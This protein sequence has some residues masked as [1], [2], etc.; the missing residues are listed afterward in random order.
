M[1]S[2]RLTALALGITGAWL[3][4]PRHLAPSSEDPSPT[5]TRARAETR[6]PDGV[7]HAEEAPVEARDRA[8]WS[9]RLLVRLAPG[10]DA[11]AVAARAGATV[12]RAPGATGLAT[13]AVPQGATPRAL[14]SRLAQDPEVLSTARSGRVEGVGDSATLGTLASV[15]WHLRSGRVQPPSR[16]LSTITVAVVD[17]GVA[18]PSAAGDCTPAPSLSSLVTV[19]P[20]DFVNDDGQACDDHQHGTHI[21]SLIASRGAVMGF[22]PHV[23]IM[24]I[25]VLDAD[26]VGDEQGLIDGLRWAVAQGA[27]VIN[28]SLSF[29]EGY[30]PSAD[31]L[32]ALREAADAGVVMVGAAGNDGGDNVT[33]PAASPLVIS[34][35]ASTLTG[36][37]AL[38]LSTYSNVGAQLDLQAP[39]GSLDADM[40]GDGYADGV[41][42]ETILPGDPDSFGYYFYEGTSQAAALVS[43]SAAWLLAY[44]AAPEEVSVALQA[45]ARARPTTPFIDGEGAGSLDLKAALALVGAGV[46]GD[47]DRVYASVLPTLRADGA[48]GAIVPTARIL[49]VNEEGAPL[50]GVAVI[51]QAHGRDG[52]DERWTCAA[53]VAGICDVELSAVSDEDGALA[54]A[55]RFTVDGVVA[56]GVMRSPTSVL[57]GSDGLE[58]LSAALGEVDTSASA[59]AFIWEEGEIDGLGALAASVTLLDLGGDGARAPTALVLTAAMAEQLFEAHALELD[60]SGSGLSTDALGV[61]ASGL[62][63]DALGIFTSSGLSTDALGVVSLSDT[64]GSGLSTDALGATEGGSVV[65]VRGSGAAATLLGVSALALTSPDQGEDLGLGLSGTPIFPGT[66]A[67]AEALQ[68]TLTQQS[69]ALSQGSDGTPMVIWLDDVLT[70]GGAETWPD[71]P[72]WGEG[73]AVD[74]FETAP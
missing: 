27:D 20:W 70:A 59:L 49:V 56:D 51:G 39:G 7:S 35:G 47:S 15:Q 54:E 25:K 1:H 22:S 74:T 68:D 73:D 53:T 21:A 63:T 26:N 29:S 52:V 14:A 11:A 33:W 9:D 67:A 4:A 69:F 71:E 57:F 65:G 3:L 31:L 48:D 45:S 23:A 19:A 28:L 34:V 50:D 58:L 37:D 36:D 43:A 62:S 13:L 72:S 61:T 30:V 46:V 24:P 10:A 41:L 18:Y 64:S 16:T 38:A 2:K 32:A 5:P 44:G 40:D 12:L 17:T 66:P 55:W 6:G 8:Y 60:L 42:A